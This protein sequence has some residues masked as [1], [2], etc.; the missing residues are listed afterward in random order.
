MTRWVSTS[1]GHH[2]TGRPKTDTAPEVAL[3]SAL[4]RRGLRF[5]TNVTLVKGCTP[6]ILLPRHRVAVF[7]DGCFWHG[8]P[9][10]GRKTPFTGPNAALWEDKMHRNCERDERATSLAAEAGWSVVR[11]WE[12]E[13]SQGPDDAAQR[14]LDQSKAD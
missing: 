7:V 3:R 5:R 1:K 11:I 13:V 10:H 8:C 14:V 9:E 2:L 12:C 6:D 4:H